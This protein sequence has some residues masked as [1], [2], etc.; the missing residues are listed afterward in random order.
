MSDIAS[1]VSTSL[2]ALAESWLKRGLTTAELAELDQFQRVWGSD[3]TPAPTPQGNQDSNDPAA[4][5]RAQAS[6][7]VIE[8]KRRSES[9]IRDVLQKLQGT[10]AQALQAHE[11]EEQ[12]ILRIVEAAR[13]LNDLRPS[14]LNLAASGAPPT[15]QVMLPQIAD[16]LANLIKTEVEQCFERCFGPLQRQLA[17]VLAQQSAAEQS[18]ASSTAQGS[19][20]QEPVKQEPA[21]QEPASASS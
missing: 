20:A 17:A 4:Q 15:A 16:R 13:S 9:A 18:G 8:A 11:S 12:A 3:G 2:R 14:A 5:V 21:K 1:E 6:Q 10:A 7:A 19:P